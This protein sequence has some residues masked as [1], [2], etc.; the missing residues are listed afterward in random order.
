MHCICHD[1]TT[2]HLILKNGVP[3]YERFLIHRPINDG[4]VFFRAHYR[5]RYCDDFAPAIR[6]LLA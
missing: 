6:E 3:E 1:D 5:H 4:L 2:R